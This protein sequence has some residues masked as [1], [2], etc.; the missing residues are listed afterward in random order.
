MESVQDKV[1]SPDFLFDL[2]EIG[3]EKELGQLTCPLVPSEK[4]FLTWTK[5]KK[6]SYV[7]SRSTS[8]KKDRCL[9]AT[10]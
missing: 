6:I 5:I 4:Y 9:N 3:E 2:P 7:K 1:A 8:H 10:V